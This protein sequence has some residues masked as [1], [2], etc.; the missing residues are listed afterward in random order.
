MTP[1]AIY[2]CNACSMYFLSVQPVTSIIHV[3]CLAHILQSLMFE[4]H[5]NC[6]CALHSRNSFSVNLNSEGQDFVY[7]LHEQ[8]VE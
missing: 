4:N 6:L 2:T 3:K 8:Y 7:K 5:R 1:V